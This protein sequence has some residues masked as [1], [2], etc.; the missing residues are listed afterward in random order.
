MK[1]TNLA[2]RHRVLN[3]L[4]NM[5][6][7]KGGIDA[8]RQSLERATMKIWQALASVYGRT[9]DVIRHAHAVRAAI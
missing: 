7:R 1:Y 3:R 9:Q 8:V 5:A 4:A 6:F 2:Y